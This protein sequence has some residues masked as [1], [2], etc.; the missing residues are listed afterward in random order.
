MLHGPWTR[1]KLK[2]RLSIWSIVY[3]YTQALSY[4]SYSITPYYSELLV[5]TNYTVMLETWR[6]NTDFQEGWSRWSVQFSSYHSSTSVVQ[7]IFIGIFE[8]TK[9]LPCWKQIFGKSCSKGF[10]IRNRRGIRTHRASG[11]YTEIGKAWAKKHNY[12]SQ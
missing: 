6:Y 9:R 8:E 5:N 2:H 11:S 7:N 4:S 1:V 12:V 3:C 10:H